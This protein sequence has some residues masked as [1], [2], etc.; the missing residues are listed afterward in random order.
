MRPIAWSLV[1]KHGK[2]LDSKQCSVMS[3]GKSVSGGIEKKGEREGRGEDVSNRTHKA[4]IGKRK[5]GAK[6]VGRF[7][8][9]NALHKFKA[10]KCMDLFSKMLP[11]GQT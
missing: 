6:R 7:I 3:M 4:R 2:R 8:R 10:K 1:S 9:V 11:G 5:G